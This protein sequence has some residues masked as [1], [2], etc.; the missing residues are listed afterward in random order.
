MWHLRRPTE[1]QT[2]DFR[3]RQ[4]NQPFS[5]PEVGQSLDGSPA[6]YNLDHNR[7]LLGH[8]QAVFEAACA[9]LSRW[10]MFPGTWASIQPA[11]TPIQKGTVAA[12]VAKTFGLWWLTA[13]RI[14]YVL[15]EQQPF[16]RFGFGYG[17]LHAHVECG[18]ERFSIEWHADDSVWYDIRAFSRPRYW[19][20]RL[21]KPLARRIQ[22]RFVRESKAAMQQICA[23]VAPR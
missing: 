23:R 8:G 13:C 1:S 14:V 9:A 18:E 6:G 22:R 2:R 11:G 7:V 16:R 17:T 19:L 5:Y 20:V 15:D 10:E 12:M 4:K 3:E 21:T